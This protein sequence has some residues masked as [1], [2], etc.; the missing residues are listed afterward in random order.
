MLSINSKMAFSGYIDHTNYNHIDWLETEILLMWINK[1][2]L[3][4]E[5]AQ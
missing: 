4:D 1:A 3:F 2:F 5:S